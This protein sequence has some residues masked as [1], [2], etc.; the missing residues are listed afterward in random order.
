MYPRCRQQT[1]QAQR[2]ALTNTA[3]NCNRMTCCWQQWMSLSGRTGR[4]RTSQVLNCQ[5]RKPVPENSKQTIVVDAPSVSSFEKHLDKHWACQEF[6]YDFKARFTW[7]WYFP[8][9]N[10]SQDMDIQAW[11]T[12]SSYFLHS[13]DSVEGWAKTQMD[14]WGELPSVNCSHDVIVVHQDGRL[15]RMVSA[16][17]WLLGW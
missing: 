10:F 6:L 4:T 13:C 3:F 14:K 9:H 12:S 1:E 15:C 7:S 16:V 8:H 17:G 2:R 5:L 11:W